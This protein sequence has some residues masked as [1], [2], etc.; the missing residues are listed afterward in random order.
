MG[1]IKI[2]EAELSLISKIEQIKEKHKVRIEGALK[3]LRIIRNQIP[4]SEDKEIQEIKT[5][6]DETIKRAENLNHAIQ[7]IEFSQEYDENKFFVA[8]AEVNDKTG[9]YYKY[10]FGKSISRE[11]VSEK[12]FIFALAAWEREVCKRLSLFKELEGASYDSLCPSLEVDIRKLL[13]EYVL[14]N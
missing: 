10:G 1:I 9:S 14:K 5:R 3:G 12:Q 4:E 2:G 11:E 6:A 7:G 13:H 8:W